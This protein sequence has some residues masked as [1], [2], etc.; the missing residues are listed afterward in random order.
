[1]DTAAAARRWVDGWRTGWSKLDPD[2]VIALYAPDAFFLSHPF[3]SPEAPE[4][5]VR[6]Q[7]ADEDFAEPWFGDPIVDGDRAA[8]EWTA[9]VRED[10]M[11]ITLSGVSLLRFD[12]EGRCIDQRDTW[13][14]EEGPV[15]REMR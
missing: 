14:V 15:A 7:F 11:D 5:Y 1:V 8:V 9:Y 13:V 4:A 2:P 3:R 12:G 10:G 6:R